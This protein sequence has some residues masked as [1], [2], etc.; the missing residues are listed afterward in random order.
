MEV[1][2]SKYVRLKVGGDIRDEDKFH[3]S[4]EKEGDSGGD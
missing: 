2:K 1:V 4:V 3:G